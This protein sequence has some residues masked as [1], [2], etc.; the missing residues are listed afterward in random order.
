VVC[1]GHEIG[2]KPHAWWEFTIA[3][4][5]QLRYVETALGWRRFFFD[6]DP[7]PTELLGTQIQ[8]SAADLCKWVFLDICRTLPET[9]EMLT[10]THDSF[11][12]QVPLVD[13]SSAK[14]WLKHKMEQPIPF[15]DIPEY[16]EGVCFPAD[17]A[18]GP[19][20]MDV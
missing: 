14:H 1:K 5:R 16:P 2:F 18:S 12:M 8:G 15:L 19:T 20:W 9:W 10:V 11:L 3:L 7:K 13:E 17:V 4:V 6:M